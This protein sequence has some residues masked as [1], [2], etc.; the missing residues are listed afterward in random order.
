VGLYC[1]STLSKRPNFLNGS[2]FFGLALLNITLTGV[3]FFLLLR[4]VYHPQGMGYYANILLHYVVPVLMLLVFIFNRERKAFRYI[5]ILTW[6]LY[7]LVYLVYSM[8]RGNITNVYPYPFLDLTSLSIIEVSLNSMIIAAGF[9]IAALLF[10]LADKK[11][12]RPEPLDT[13][14]KQR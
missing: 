8:I 6:M 10:V 5:Y 12:L 13:L 2:W 4:N 11:L 3:V 14:D 9:G 1:I 7:P